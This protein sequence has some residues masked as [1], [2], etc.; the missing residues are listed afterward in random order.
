MIIPLMPLES[1]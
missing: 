1:F